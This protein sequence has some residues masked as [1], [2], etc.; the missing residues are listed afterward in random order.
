MATLCLEKGVFVLKTAYT[1]RSQAK[2]L[3]CRSD[4]R[5]R[6]WR[7]PPD[8]MLEDIRDYMS[9]LFVTGDA[10]Q[11]IVGRCLKNDYLVDLKG[12]DDALVQHPQGLDIR[13]SALA[14]G[15]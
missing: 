13:T 3:G 8:V 15:F 11:S 14:S 4:A 6:V 5:E 2:A 1:E 7:I 12:A 9:P 10:I